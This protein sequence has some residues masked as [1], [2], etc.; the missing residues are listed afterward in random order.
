MQRTA[1]KN[2]IRQKHMARS[3]CYYYGTVGHFLCE[4]PE[5][6]AS[7]NRHLAMAATINMTTEPDTAILNKQSEN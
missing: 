3:E 4:C 5:C 1:E 2:C 7:R 6:A